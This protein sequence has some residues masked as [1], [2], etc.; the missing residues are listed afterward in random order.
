MANHCSITQNQPAA[1][2]L[3]QDGGTTLLTGNS[4]HLPSHPK[5]KTEGPH[6]QL[7]HSCW[8]SSLWHTDGC[9]EMTHILINPS[10]EQA[11][12]VSTEVDKGVTVY[13]LVLG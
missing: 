3:R 13:R 7:F 4:D 10:V 8:G 12:A 6:Q 2:A 9:I 1:A 5:Q 11:L